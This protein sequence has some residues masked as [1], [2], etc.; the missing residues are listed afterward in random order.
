MIGF[1]V[2]AFFVSF[3][4]RDPI[5]LMASLL[6][7]LYVSAQSMLAREAHPA[8]AVVTPQPKSAAGW[9]VARSMWRTSSG[10]GLQSGMY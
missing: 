5:Y 9:R 4:W 7:G 8:A 3:A 1:A 2:T 10:G 6:T